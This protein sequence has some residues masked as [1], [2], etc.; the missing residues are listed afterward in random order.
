MRK[1]AEKC[2]KMRE[3]AG[4]CGKNVRKSASGRI[5]NLIVL[6]KALSATGPMPNVSCDV[7]DGGDVFVL[8]S[9]LFHREQVFLS[10]LFPRALIL[11]TG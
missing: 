7:S 2:G 5:G 1:N 6:S 3:N 8:T 10:L 11:L 4:K 9:F